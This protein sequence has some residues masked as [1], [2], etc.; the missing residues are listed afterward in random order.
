MGRRAL[1]NLALAYLACAGDPEAAS[2]SGAVR[3]R[4]T[5]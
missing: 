3:A 5:T 4:P 1:K 2:W